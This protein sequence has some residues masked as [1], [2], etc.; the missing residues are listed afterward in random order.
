MKLHSLRLLALAGLAFP[1]V[2][3]A[4]D[5]VRVAPTIAAP[6]SGKGQVVFYR[7]GGLGPRSAARCAR[8]AR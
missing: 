6:A 8:M 2:A 1:A 4:A 7:P 3:Y 5:D